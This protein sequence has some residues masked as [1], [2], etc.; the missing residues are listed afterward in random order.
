MKLCIIGLVGPS[1]AGKTAIIKHLTERYSFSRTHAGMAVKIAVKVGFNLSE[2]EVD[3]DL[4]EI[5]SDKLG[6]ATP[7]AVLEQVGQ[8]VHIHAPKATSI[9]WRDYVVSHSYPGRRIIADGIRRQTE[10]DMVHELGGIVLRIGGER[11]KIDPNKPLDLVQQEVQEDVLIENSGTL[12][13]LIQKV[14]DAAKRYLTQ[15]VIFD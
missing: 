14:D 7:R 6:G 13:E 8:A 5:P 4:R 11:A 9:V 3:G 1:G 15:A 12:D 10:A 2:E